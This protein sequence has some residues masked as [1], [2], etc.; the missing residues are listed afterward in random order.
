MN[1]TELINYLSEKNISVKDF[2]KITK[3][4]VKRLNAV[5]N[6]QAFFSEGELNRVS[7]FLGVSKNELMHGVIERKGELPEVAEQNNLNHFRYY[8]KARLR[9]PKR[10][11]NLFDLIGGFSF[12]AIWALYIISLFMGVSGLPTILRSADIMLLCFIIPAC[13]I[14]FLNDIA[15]PKVIEKRTTPD[16]KINLETMGISLLLLVFSISAFVNDFIPVEA[17]ALIIAGAIALSVL[18]IV[19]P[20]KN[21]PFNNRF[22]QFVVYMLPTAILIVA[23][24]F[25]RNYVVKI[26]PEEEGAAGEALATASDMFCMVLGLLIFG[27]FYFSMVQYYNV[28]A[29]GAGKFF[30]PCQKSK[31]ISKGNLS[32]Y[33]IAYII[34]GCV[35]FLSIWVSQGL[36]LK[37]IFTNTLAEHEEDVNW[38]AEFITD[39]E[40][41]YKKGEYDVVE[42]EGMKIK[43]PEAYY[44]DKK[45]EYNIT[46]KVGDDCLLMFQKPIELE[47]GMS[48]L[49]LFN[50][51]FGEGKI[52][53]EQKEAMKQ[54]YIKYFGFYPKTMY[55]W[56]KIEGL[57]TLDDLDI[58]NPRKTVVMSTALM[59]KAVASVPDSEYYLYENGDLYAT[60]IIHTI[61]NEEK[62]DKEMVSISF[63]SPNL[64]YGMTLA[65]PDQDNVKT[66]EEVTKILNSI[67]LD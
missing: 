1:M 28:F 17:L 66:I 20:F 55:E 60:I 14:F 50:E 42:Y 53:E 58:F 65:R 25:V 47:S 59:M 31:S 56:Q 18:F 37:F 57:V 30:K 4:K 45:T 43:I 13:G 8:I 23:E 6:N 19:S 63:G 34:I 15:R 5:L 3:I 64:E 9:G 38:T 61:E 36:Y 67:N 46:Y 10:L 7:A 40:A 24:V 51:N 54:D 52:T 26:T 11:F 62:G 16:S 49:D 39:F 22:L 29:K 41:Q 33:I 12:V 21:K 44:F 32:R 35:V 2:A 48:D 27:V